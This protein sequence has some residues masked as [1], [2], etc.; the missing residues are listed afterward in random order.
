MPVPVVSAPA[1]LAPAG[2]VPA[3]RV[4]ANADASDA[5]ASDAN[6]GAHTSSSATSSAGTS[7]DSRVSAD[8]ALLHQ[9]SHSDVA[10]LTQLAV[11]LELVQ[12]R[13]AGQ[14]ARNG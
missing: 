8:L 7:T 12:Q 6:A 11:L 5:N 9:H 4:N 1:V 14:N 3:V 13:R 2:R 10:T